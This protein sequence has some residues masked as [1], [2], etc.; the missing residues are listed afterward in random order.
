MKKSGWM[1]QICPSTRYLLK[2]TRQRATEAHPQVLVLAPKHIPYCKTVLR[3]QIELS[4]ILEAAIN[5]SQE[6]SMKILRRALVSTGTPF[7]NVVTKHNI[8]RTVFIRKLST[9]A[10][11]RNIDVV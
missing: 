2:Y 4:A 6:L 10:A 9:H 11:R 8:E 1:P 5:F 7:K 3:G